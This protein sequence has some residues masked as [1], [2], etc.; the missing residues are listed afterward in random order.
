MLVD[1]GAQAPAGAAPAAALPPL[2]MQLGSTPT[3]RLRVVQVPALSAPRVPPVSSSNVQ[4]MSLLDAVWPVESAEVRE[5]EHMQPAMMAVL[6]AVGEAVSCR[7]QLQDTHASSQ[8]RFPTSK[9]DCTGLAGGVEAWSQV[10]TH[11]EFKLGKEAG[12]REVMLGQLIQRC[13]GVGSK[14]RAPA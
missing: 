2:V 3:P 5:E 6:R 8:L 14:G 7:M 4:P 10:V 9:P 11:F 13:A 1:A 12:D